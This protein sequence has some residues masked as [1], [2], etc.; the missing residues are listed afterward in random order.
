MPSIEGIRTSMSTTWG[1][2]RGAI[3]SAS[4]PVR[5]SPMTSSSSMSSRARRESRKPSL[6]STTITRTRAG[7]NGCGLR[8]SEAALAMA[9]RV[10]RPRGGCAIRQSAVSAEPR[11]PRAL[12]Q[13]GVVKRPPPVP[14][15]RVNIPSLTRACARPGSS[16]EPAS[17]GGPPPLA[18]LQADVLAAVAVEDRLVGAR[19]TR[20][21]SGAQGSPGRAEHRRGR[22]RSRAGRRR[23]AF[24]CVKTRAR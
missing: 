1:R 8:S 24:A 22:G 17:T 19:E 14:A 6:S 20:R 7:G 21:R 18:I 9:R 10:S 5:A 11:R 3:S 2:I 23:K 4:A 16:P 12:S 13:S 15:P